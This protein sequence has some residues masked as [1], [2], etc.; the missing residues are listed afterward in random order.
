MINN[1]HP[2]NHLSVS[3]PLNTNRTIL[4]SLINLTAGL[5]VFGLSK[6]TEVSGVNLRLTQEPNLGFLAVR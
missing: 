6:K 1:I 5:H 3:P 4:V 2:S